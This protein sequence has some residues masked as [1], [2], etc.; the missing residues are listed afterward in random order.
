MDDPD[1]QNIQVSAKMSSEINILINED[2]ARKQNQE[3]LEWL[4]EHINA[5][6]LVFKYLNILNI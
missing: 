2:V 6:G 4:D 5:K 1:Y 3:R